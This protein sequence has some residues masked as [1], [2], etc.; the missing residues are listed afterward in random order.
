[1]KL[2]LTAVLLLALA[3]LPFLAPSGQS[4][5]PAV[6]AN[7]IKHELLVSYDL[8]GSTLAGPFNMTLEVFNDG[9][10]KIAGV[11]AAGADARIANVGPATAR[12]FAREL[13]DA[14]AWQLSDQPGNFADVPLSTVTVLRGIDDQKAHVFSFW[15]GTNEYAPVQASLTLFV[16][17]HFP[18]F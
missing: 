7:L 13:Y 10:A 9:T 1:M 15:V 6:A 16:S 2:R 12:Q 18:G 4:A 3:S 11:T 8:T 17:T 14:G 5:S